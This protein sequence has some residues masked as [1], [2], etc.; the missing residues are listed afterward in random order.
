MQRSTHPDAR[1]SR[2]E[3]SPSCDTLVPR[4]ELTCLSHPRNG[5]R[6][7]LPAVSGF[8]L[9]DEYFPALQL[10]AEQVE[11]YEWQMQQVVQ[12]ALVEYNLHEAMEPV[13]SYASGTWNVVAN[14]DGLTTVETGDRAS[15]VWRIFGRV[16]GDYRNFLDFFYAESSA[17][18]FEWNQIMYGNTVDA[19][20]L[21]NIHTARSGKPH[22]YLGAKWTCLQPSSF[23]RRRD[24][25]FLEYMVYTKDLKGRDVG[26]RVILPL[27]VPECPPFPDQFKVARIKTN[28]VSIV[29]PADG[30]SSATQLFM[31][32][33]NDYAGYRVPKAYLKKVM[34]TLAN[35]TL[36]ADSRRLS[37]AT[38]AN[39]Q[40]W[41]DKSSRKTCRIC[42]RAFSATR[43]RRH[44]RMCGDV[45][46]SNCL[47]ERDAPVWDGA[48]KQRTDFQVMK[49]KFCKMCVANTR[50]SDMTSLVSTS[51]GD[52][53]DT[54]SLSEVSGCES[55]SARAESSVNTEEEEEDDGDDDDDDDERFSIGLDEDEDDACTPASLGSRAPAL[56]AGSTLDTIDDRDEDDDEEE[57]LSR[58]G[59][60]D[61]AEEIDTKDMMAMSQIRQAAANKQAV[62]SLSR[63]MIRSV[64]PHTRVPSP[65]SISARIA[66]QEDLLRRMM[67]AASKNGS[68][69]AF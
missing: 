64:G 45:F 35:M 23:S 50:F 61:I 62:E 39:P 37:M 27:D 34:A 59:S 16:N 9:P 52:F 54:N 55:V 28:I 66:E 3:S 17:Q 22:V 24:N 48:R 4:R 32:C 13:S 47:V 36:L 25:C 12:N 6:A 1:A 15:H 21:A 67:L 41:V 29:R 26:V 40:H 20:V 42:S 57:V 68:Q 53:T 8:P 51:S 33:Q 60:L 14:V 11:R 46:C 58:R 7:P 56:S 69:P 49:T 31:M 44:C 5:S 63:S 43:R 19:A 18:L 10:T 65:Q 2:Y 30:N 38:F